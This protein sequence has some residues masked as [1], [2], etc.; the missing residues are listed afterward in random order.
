M[1]YLDLE[2]RKVALQ[3]LHLAFGQEKSESEILNIA[4]KSFQNLG[5]TAIEFFRL[6]KMD[7]ET[8]KKKVTIEGL[9]IVKKALEGK[10]G[11]LLLL[12]HFGN[13]ELS[14]GHFH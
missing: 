2:H 9:E 12:S 5:M 4:K 8:F 3:N 7:V 10:K 14:G 11:I 1:Y 6:P 13:W